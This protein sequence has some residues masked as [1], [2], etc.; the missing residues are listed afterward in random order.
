MSTFL[1]PNNM[2]LQDQLLYIKNI[3]PQ[4]KSKVLKLVPYL[5]DMHN[6]VVH[7]KALVLC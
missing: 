7:R 2:I 4:C 5:N 3:G 1:A 6:Y